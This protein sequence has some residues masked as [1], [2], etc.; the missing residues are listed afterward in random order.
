MTGKNVEAMNS[1]YK[2]L[3]SL[4][5]RSVIN[6]FS[7]FEFQLQ[8]YKAKIC[9]SSCGRILGNN[10]FCE[11]KT[12]ATFSGWSWTKMR[13]CWTNLISELKNCDVFLWI[14]IINKLT[15]WTINANFT[16]FETEIIQKLSWMM[17]KCVTNSLQNQ[18]YYN[19][20]AQRPQLIKKNPRILQ[21]IHWSKSGT[22]MTIMTCPHLP[23][24][25]IFVLP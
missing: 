11:T 20:I 25:F 13:T 12:S 19:N 15:F 18:V 3:H 17:K 2:M 5:D 7:L 14:K 24:T 23:V 6:L 16:L 22:N 4:C 8:L 21:N 10:V 9:I 1:K